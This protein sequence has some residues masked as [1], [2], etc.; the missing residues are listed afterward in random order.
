[1]LR[2]IDQLDVRPLA[3]IKGAFGPF[4]SPDSQWI[5]FFQSDGE[6]GEI[7]KVSI[8][9]GPAIALCRIVGVPL[10]ASWGD[11]NTI[12]FATNDP[13]TGLWQ[14]SA[15]GG[16]PAVLT[17]P[18]T[19]QGENG[20]VFPSV[21]TGGR[22]VLFTI[23]KAGAES[24][25]AILDRETGRQ[26]TLVRG[27]S[28]ATYVESGHLIYAA[29]GT[30]RVVGFDPVGLEVLG[31]PVPVVEA[32]MMTT[33]GAAHYA[34]SR[35]G[36]LIYAPGGTGAQ[37]SLVWVDR[38][39]REVPI[40]VPP[41]TYILPR[42][43]PDGT[44]VVFQVWDPDSDL[45]IWDLVRDMRMRLTFDPAN[46]IMPVWTPDSRRIIFASLR[47]GTSAY[48]LYSVAT[49][50]TGTVERLTTSPR[51]HH[52]T[53]ITPDGTSI[54]GYHSTPDGDGDIIMI[55][56]RRPS[57]AVTLF[58]TPFHEFFPEVSPNG[59]YVA[60][61]SNATGTRDVYVRPFPHVDRGVWKV[62]VEGGTSAAWARNGREMFYL[63]GSKTLTAVPVQTSGP[64]FS[65]GTPAKLFDAAQ[66]SSWTP[67]RYYD[68]S[69]DGQRFLMIK[70]GAIRN[71]LVVVE[72]WIEA[73]KA[74]VP[75]GS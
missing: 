32:V 74:R 7:K 51:E 73:L 6:H 41:L 25:V 46:D 11:D 70:D 1:M 27:G 64:T 15:S 16:E 60:Y 13:G 3:G 37:Q 49:D 61:E 55:P 30:L 71:Q 52:A 75:P 42:L 67:A 4:F 40:N 69:P 45:W 48:N 24:Q 28:D 9:G 53:S 50:G 57:E 59:R 62:S 20:H 29:A 12:V 23:T 2:A 14:V 34:V 19:P 17:K 10:G 56:M 72:R 39:G 38:K 31:D 68:V 63:D 36:N 58:H 66:Y 22:G 54:V 33:A 65:A 18:D 5:G 21:L 8:R 44:R 35:T 43:S 47:G 26:K